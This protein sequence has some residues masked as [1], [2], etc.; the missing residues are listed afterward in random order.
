[1]AYRGYAQR[2]KV[3]VSQSKGEIE[4]YLKKHGATGFI[5]G[6]N[7]GQSML[8]FEMRDRRLKFLVPMPTMGRGTTENKVKQETRRR[9]R[10]LLLVLKAKL[11]AVESKIVTFDDEFL[12]HIIV[13]GNETVGEQLRNGLDAAL[14]SGDLPPLLG[15]GPT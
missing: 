9:Y 1:M 12:A 6:E 10:A 11:E 4:S 13:R 15:P 2:T 14:K 3:P 5:F 7:I 8:V